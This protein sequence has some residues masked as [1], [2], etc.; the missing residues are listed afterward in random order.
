MT[1]APGEG[2]EPKT[3]RAPGISNTVAGRKKLF[4]LSG[5]GCEDGHYPVEKPGG[6]EMGKESL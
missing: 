2:T 5:E 1:P 4:F 6:A 3:K